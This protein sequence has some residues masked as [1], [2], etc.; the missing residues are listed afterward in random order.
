MKK[1]GFSSEKPGFFEKKRIRSQRGDIRIN[2]NKR[3]KE[4]RITQTRCSK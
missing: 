3:L 2:A 1:P 4:K